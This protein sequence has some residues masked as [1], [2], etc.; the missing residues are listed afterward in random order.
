MQEKWSI[1]KYEEI[2]IMINVSVNGCAPKPLML[3]LR[4]G[5]FNYVVPTYL[6]FT[7]TDG[8]VEYTSIDRWLCIVYNVK[9]A[10]SIASFFFFLVLGKVFFDMVQGSTF[11]PKITISD[12]MKGWERKSILLYNW[13]ASILI[14]GIEN[15]NMSAKGWLNVGGGVGWFG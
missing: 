9:K 2:I 5:N 15:G 3:G 13:E 6:V 4:I 8:Y 14:N 10:V 11:V 7:L 12:E 1:K